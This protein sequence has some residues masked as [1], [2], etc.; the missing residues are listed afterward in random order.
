MEG[1]IGKKL[2]VLGANT[3]TIPLIETAK[4]LGVF[5]YVTDF[6]PAAP[7]K[8]HANRSLDIDGLDIPALVN[9]CITEKIDGVMVGVADRL[10]Q[11]YY[12]LCTALNLPCYASKEQC[13]YFTNKSNF[14]E[15]CKKFDINTIPNFNKEYLNSKSRKS[16]VYPVFVKPTDAN[17]GKGISICYNEIELED[18]I[19]KAKRSSKTNGYLIERLM[20]CDNMFISYTFINGKILVSATSDTYTTSDQGSLSRVCVG[21][22]YPSKFTNLY[23]EQL[24][25]KMLLMFRNI[26]IKN[27]VFSISA[28]VEEGQIFLYDPGFRLQGEAPD[29]L[30][31]EICGYDQKELLVHF[32]LTNIMGCTQFKLADNMFKGKVYAETIWILLKIG[33]ISKIQGLEILNL[34]NC[35]VKYLKRFNIGDIVSKEM[36]GTESQVFARIY[37]VSNNLNILRDK[38]TLIKYS[39]KIYDVNN[40]EMSLKSI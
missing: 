17:S 10:I 28:F 33:R 6:N 36:I 13:Q 18:G 5:V 3:E 15:L 19:K 25:D 30:I 7:A 2:L 37:L 39:L 29:I 9:L 20:N 1:L 22:F 14:N 27:G 32:S 8:K 38:T 24:H 34:S 35:V 4:S 31:N 21:N 11:S 40:V 26:N 12:A 16:I 23:F